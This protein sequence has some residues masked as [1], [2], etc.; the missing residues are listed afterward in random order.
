MPLA[1][2]DTCPKPAETTKTT[3]EPCAQ[4]DAA[5]CGATVAPIPLPTTSTAPRKP[6]INSGVANHGTGRHVVHDRRRPTWM[7][8]TGGA[9]VLGRRK[10]MTPPVSRPRCGDMHHSGITQAHSAGLPASVLPI[11]AAHTLYKHTARTLQGNWTYPHPQ[12][13]GNGGVHLPVMVVV[14]KSASLE[15]SRVLLPARP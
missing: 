5:R 2:P 12:M 13:P 15:S 11:A 7:L 3:D 14:R 8:A 10:S 4:P 6:R 1:M 9:A